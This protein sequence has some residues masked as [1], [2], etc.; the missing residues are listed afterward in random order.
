VLAIVIAEGVAIA[1]LGILVL[2]L[3]RSH[4][5]ILKALHELGAGLEL[6]KEAGTGVTTAATAGSPGPMPVELETGVVPAT[7]SNN[8]TARDIVGTTLDRR[9]RTVT[10]TAP[11]TRTLL[12]FLSSGCSVCQT[13]WEEFRGGVD[14]PG[15][16]ELRI[17]AKGPEEESATSLRGLAGG[18]Q[19]LQSSAAWSDYDIPG[20][21]YFVYVEAGVIT[22]EGSATTWPQVRD[23]MAQG[24]SDAEEA[25]AAAGRSGP[26]SLIG[27]DY[28]D[29]GE[30]DN[31]SRIDGELLAAGIRPGDASLYT[32]PDP[33]TRDEKGHVHPHTEHGHAVEAHTDH[34][35]ARAAHHHD[36]R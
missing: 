32:S 19:V 27:E 28:V 5:L 11:G 31:L 6:E 7:R 17:I 9:E 20:S 22:G 16:G 30:R 21:P 24:V 34:H 23:L 25:R 26:G 2:G 15:Q 1:L 13:F 33:E 36:H 35:H 10:V 4:A 12:A 18:L 3:L 14:V 29:R 8:S